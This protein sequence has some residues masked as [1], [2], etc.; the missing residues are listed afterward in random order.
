[1]T[2]VI[3]QIPVKS[4]ILRWILFIASGP[5]QSSSKK[6]F[7][8]LVE[9][10]LVQLLLKLIDGPGQKP[11]RH[12]EAFDAMS[13]ALETVDACFLKWRHKHLPRTDLKQNFQGCLGEKM[14][15][16][17]MRGASYQLFTD[18]W[19]VQIGLQGRHSYEPEVARSPLIF[20]EVF[21]KKDNWSFNYE[22]F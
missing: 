8:T 2:D 7:W 16:I 12:V 5:D 11:L 17:M 20:K 18:E 4:Q 3:G 1:M 13:D 22:L 14:D 15:S 9:E 21:W 6:T 10:F 19:E